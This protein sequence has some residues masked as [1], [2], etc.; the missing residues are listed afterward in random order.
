MCISVSA[1]LVLFL[2]LVS[3]SGRLFILSYS[4]GLFLVSSLFPNERKE[5]V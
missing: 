5:K 2:W 3:F 1:F 4:V